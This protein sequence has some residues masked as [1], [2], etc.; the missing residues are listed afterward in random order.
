[1]KTIT[2]SDDAYRKLESI[3]DG[4]SFS[5]TIEALI[6]ASVS[7]RIDKLLGL[8]SFTTGKEDELERVVEGIRKRAKART[9]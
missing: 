4:R 5:E 2:I 6:R 1:M 3:K 9:L 7:K 8:G